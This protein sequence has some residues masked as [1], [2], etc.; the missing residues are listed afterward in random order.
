MERTNMSSQDKPAKPR[1]ALR[2]AV[3]NDDVFDAAGREYADKLEAMYRRKRNEVPFFEEI[4][5]TDDWAP[6]EKVIES[7]LEILRLKRGWRVVE[8]AWKVAGEGSVMDFTMTP[9]PNFKL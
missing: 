5:V 3:N 8:Y 7:A 1:P 2:I 9:P 6:S 4:T